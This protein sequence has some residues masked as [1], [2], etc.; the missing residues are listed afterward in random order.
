[1]LIFLILGTGCVEKEIEK[2]PIEEPE[3][4]LKGVSLSPRSSSAED[5]TGF[6]EEATKAGDIVMWA[7]D[8][9]ELS[10]EQGAPKVVSGLA[11]TYG[12]IPLVEVTIHSNGQLVRPLNSDNLQTYRSKA[13]SF[14]EEFKPEYLGL[15]I[16]I[17]SVY[18]ESP[19]DFDLCNF[20]Q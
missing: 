12:H 7:G 3:G 9:N 17:N 6:F 14:A 18:V 13:L 15:G 10:T 16:E 1:M 8:W 20:L 4:T 5:F 11:S 19:V 2:T